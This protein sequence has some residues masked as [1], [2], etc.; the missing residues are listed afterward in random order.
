MVEVMKIMG[1]SFKRSYACTAAL[2][3]PNPEAGHHRPTPPPETLG[4]SQT[5]LGQSLEGSL[6]LYP[7]SWCTK[8][9]VCACQESISQSCVSSGTFMVGLMAISSKRA[10]AI[11]KSAATRGPA[12]AAVT[13]DPYL[14]RRD[15]NTA[16]HCWPVPLQETLKHSSPLLT[17]TSTGDTQTQQ[18]TADPYLYRRHSN[19]AVTA[20]P[21]LYRRDSNTAVTADPY[22]Y[23]RHSNTLL[24]QSLWGITYGIIQDYTVEV[25]NTCKGLDLIEC[26]NN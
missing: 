1:T 16:V 19:T 2:T 11:S 20:D 5:S 10:Y 22:L 25:T 26:L 12:S 4:H 18:S 21:Y 17:R 13:A 6:L 24:S 3:A 9:S 8:V 7:G 23:R 15:S 14:H